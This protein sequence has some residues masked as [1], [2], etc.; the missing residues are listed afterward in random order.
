MSLLP[1]PDRPDP[2]YCQHCQEGFLEVRDLA[3]HRGRVHREAL[4]EAEQASYE[5]ALEE[6]KAWLVRFRRHT[7]AGLATLP[8]FFV[9]AIVLVAG[10]AYR[11]RTMLLLLPIPGILGF[12]VVT[13]LM[14]YRHQR[15]HAAASTEDA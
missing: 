7:R 3:L 2:V 13:Y 15:A 5:A 11:A 9:Y 1:S 8:I 4:D 6:E 10:L 12:A 14:V